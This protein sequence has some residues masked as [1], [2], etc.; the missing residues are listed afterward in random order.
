MNKETY[1]A[2]KALISYFRSGPTDAEGVYDKELTRVESWID[3]VAKE[4]DENDDLADDNCGFCGKKIEGVAHRFNNIF[5]CDDC[6][7]SGK[8]KNKIV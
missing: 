3:E 2:L 6:W 5:Y 8:A 1:E 7:I 4:Y